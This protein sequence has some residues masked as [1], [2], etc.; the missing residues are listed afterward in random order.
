MRG[1]A[2]VVLLLVL[3]ATLVES[4]GKHG[5]GGHVPLLGD[6]KEFGCR[7]EVHYVTHYRTKFQDVS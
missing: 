2:L 1:T 5:I 4:G 7:P 3:D 6:V